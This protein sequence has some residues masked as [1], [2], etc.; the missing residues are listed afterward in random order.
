[1]SVQ[2]YSYVFHGYG[3]ENSLMPLVQFMESKGHQVLIIDDQKSTYNRNELYYRLENLKRQSKII[4]I[5]SAHLWFDEFNYHYLFGKNFNMI[6]VI[7][8]IDFLKPAYSVFYPHDMESFVHSSE[9]PWLDLFDMVMLP[10]AHNLYYRL[11]KL[12]RRVEVV[13]WIKKQRPVHPE[14]DH[15]NPLYSPV[16]FPSNIITFYERLGAKGYADWFRRFTGSGIPLKMPAGD[17]GVTSILSQEGYQ[18]LDSSQSV[19]D[20]MAGHNLII[21]SGHSSIIFE[22]AFSG[23]PVISLLDGVFPDEEYLKNLSGIKGIYPMHPEELLEFIKDINTRHILLEGGPDILMPFDFERVYHYLT[24]F[25]E[26]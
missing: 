2:T 17:V 16:F 1:M 24:G 19:Y 8:L 3:G 4:L 14:I 15:K 11:L 9:I 18:F 26:N 12:C 20:V 21:G 13:G 22:A 5:S 10:Y 7:E 25:S 23:I 6:S